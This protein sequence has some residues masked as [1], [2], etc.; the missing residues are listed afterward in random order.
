MVLALCI[1]SVLS[2]ITALAAH[3]YDPVPTGLSPLLSLYSSLF[4]WYCVVACIQ[5]LNDTST[6]NFSKNSPFRLF[7]PSDPVRID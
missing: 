6:E 3:S 2:L 1:Y 7:K 4:S 5:R